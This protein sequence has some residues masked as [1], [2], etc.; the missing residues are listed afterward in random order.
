M[1][2]DMRDIEQ[3]SV[4]FGNLLAFAHQKVPK[5]M[6]NNDVMVCCLQLY[7]FFVLAYFIFDNLLTYFNSWPI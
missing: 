3:G 1:V 5:M 2:G 6:E 7:F 4:L